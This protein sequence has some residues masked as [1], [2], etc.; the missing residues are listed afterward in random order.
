MRKLSALVIVA[1]MITSLVLTGCAGMTTGA[2]GAGV[3]PEQVQS[4]AKYLQATVQTL[5][6]AYAVAVAKHPDKAAA[7]ES[8][9]KP[10]LD[11][12]STAVDVYVALAES[13]D[14]AEADQTWA[15][16]KDLIRT[17]VTALAPYALAAIL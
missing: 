10:V 15:I 8:Q 13:A 7:M 1:F 17:A 4:G 2:S 12:L 6:S 3:T 9:I 16:A 5:N 11:E 14:P